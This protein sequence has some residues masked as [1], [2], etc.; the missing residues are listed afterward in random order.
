MRNRFG[1]GTLIEQRITEA[2]FAFI[3]C[4]DPVTHGA[5][6]SLKGSVIRSGIQ[7]PAFM[8]FSSRERRSVQ[9]D[10]Q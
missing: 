2:L 6:H 8:G 10:F 1:Q 9:N 7:G 4:V 3:I 5:S